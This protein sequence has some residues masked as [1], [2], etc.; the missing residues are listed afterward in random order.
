VR[1]LRALAGLID[2]E[3]ELLALVRRV[4][5]R[6]SFAEVYAEQHTGEDIMRSTRWLRVVRSPGLSGFAVR[7][8]AGV[9][10]VEAAGSDFE[11]SSI[12]QSAEAVERRLSAAGKIGDPPGISSSLTGRFETR[13]ARLLSDEGTEALTQRTDELLAPM[14]DRPGIRVATVSLGW[15]DHERLYLNSAGAHCWSRI[16]R[17]GGS[18]L[19]VASEA[20]RTQVDR[21]H[22]GAAGGR[23]ITDPFDEQVTATVADG[24]RAM[25]AA[26]APP[27]GL[28]NVILDPGATATFSHESL[29][30][31]AEADQFVRNRSYL[32]PLLGQ[33]IAPE[34]VT[35][36]DDGTVPGG[37]GSLPFDDEGNPGQR[38]VL[39]D[40]GKFVGALHDRSTAAALGARPTGNTR[41]ATFA[42][43]AYVR[44][45]NSFL[46]A[47]DRELDDL[48]AEAGDGVL[49]E[50]WFSGV[51]DPAG[52]QMQ[53][54]VLKGHRIEHGR[55]TDLLG[56]M[57]LSRPVLDFLKE[58]RGIAKRE[59]FEWTP[60]T[61]GKGRTE[62]LPVG[63][64][65]SYVLSRG[66]I[67]PT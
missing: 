32:R 28:M 65:G 15:E 26:K 46:E 25:L 63:D 34:F 8:W 6:T 38:T 37:W 31:G 30:H 21:R 2:H 7:A 47:G 40:R 50:N 43:R 10:W 56:A 18:A 60:G 29:G 22:V 13:P 64:G 55:L 1:S 54:K 17:S 11:A 12:S 19:A 39:I 58:I 16:T 51:E 59:L 45:T 9:R 48:V 61:C 53:I 3:P 42:H 49:L 23:E 57:A 62:F 41:R 66:V 24:A 67:G 36:V 27:T 35:L 5:R 14:R 33:M 4:G 20:G 44:M 52:G